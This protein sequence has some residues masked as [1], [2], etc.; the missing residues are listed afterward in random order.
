MSLFFHCRLQGLGLSL[1]LVL[2]LVKV[3]LQELDYQR[4]NP[5]GFVDVDVVAALDDMKLEV[6]V[7]VRV[8]LQEAPSDFFRH[9]V[10]RVGSL[11]DEQR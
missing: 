11:D 6:R 7:R 9:V 10:L 3:L 1:S 2:G 4:R 8:D 5:L